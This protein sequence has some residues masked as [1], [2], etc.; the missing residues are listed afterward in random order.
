MRGVEPSCLFGKDPAA[1]LRTCL[2]RSGAGQGF[3]STW[4]LNLSV[5]IY[6]ETKVLEVRGVE[7]LSYYAQYKRLQ[8]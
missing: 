5:K 6:G 8:V 4:F 2:G 7:P 3:D 1:A